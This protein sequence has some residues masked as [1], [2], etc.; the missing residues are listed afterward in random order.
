MRHWLQASRPWCWSSTRT[1][2]KILARFLVEFSENKEGNLGY[3][4]SK[5]TANKL[6]ALLTKSAP[7]PAR[8]TTN[9]TPRFD[10][11]LEVTGDEIHSSFFPCVAV[12]YNSTTNS[13]E[14]FTGSCVAID[15]NELPLTVG[16]RYRAMHCGINNVSEG[17]SGSGSGSG[18]VVNQVFV[19]QEASESGSAPAV[20]NLKDSVRLVVTAALPANFYSNGSSGVGATLTATSNGA[21]P[22]TDGFST[23]LNDE[24][25]VTAE[26]TASRNGVYRITDLGS[27][28]T[29]WVLTRRSDMD[30]AADFVSAIVPVRLGTLSTNTLWFCT[31]Y[32]NPTVGSTSIN[33]KR[34]SGNVDGPATATT[35]T[36]IALWDGTS[37]RQLKNCSYNIGSNINYAFNTADGY[38]GFSAG[39]GYV[40]VRAND[41]LTG[42]LLTDWAQLGAG[43]TGGSGPGL[44]TSHV[45][46]F[47]CSLNN[48]Q[49][50]WH[51]Q[52]YY[53]GRFILKAPQNGS[54]SSTPKYSIVRISSYTPTTYDG[55]DAT[56]TVTVSGVPKTMTIVGGLVVG[57]A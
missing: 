40:Y 19:V 20:N 21:F 18:S 36:A 56:C 12:Q 4:L 44:T 41:V 35:D 2:A 34:V 37:G 26:S 7:L 57:L 13:W 6:K 23:N 42:T 16:K 33:F 38:P 55:I 8:A 47:T 46:G 31:N 43:G 22:F 9:T 15:C 39:S 30:S 5:R 49:S 14:E 54:G 3:E 51:C 53:A 11:F 50:E 17:V 10:C 52:T 32:T 27:V 45:G 25:L 48:Y 1:R 24:I 29:P 28:S